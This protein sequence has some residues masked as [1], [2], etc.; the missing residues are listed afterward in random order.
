M[1]DFVLFIDI[2]EMSVGIGGFV[3]LVLN[4]VHEIPAEANVIDV[5]VSLIHFNVREPKPLK[6]GGEAFMHFVSHLG[7][8]NHGCNFTL[9]LIDV[10][11]FY[12]GKGD[13][14]TISWGCH[15]RLLC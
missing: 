6:K 10:F 11:D 12:F 8:R 14:P 9:F 2:Y 4:V 1:V 3:L 5:A 7:L 15:N 13:R